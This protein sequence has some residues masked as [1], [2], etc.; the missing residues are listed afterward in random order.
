[1]KEVDHLYL[2]KCVKSQKRGWSRSGGVKF[3]RKMLK[4][5]KGG[6]RKEHRHFCMIWR[7]AVAISASKDKAFG[8]CELVLTFSPKIKLHHL[9]YY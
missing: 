4:N 5:G 2:P 6:G 3:L 1:M 8:M 9:I 7:N